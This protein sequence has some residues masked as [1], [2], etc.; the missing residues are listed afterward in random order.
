MNPPDTM[1]GEEGI[2]PPRG[3]EKNVKNMVTVPP[4]GRDAG[5]TPCQKNVKSKRTAAPS[6][7]RY[8]IVEVRRT[9][10]ILE[11]AQKICKRLREAGGISCLLW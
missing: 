6:P 2:T 9:F 1:D 5:L 8:L 7:W 4:R 10:K 11:S 3:T